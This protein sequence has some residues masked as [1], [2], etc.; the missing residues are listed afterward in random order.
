MTSIPIPHTA[1]AAWEAYKSNPGARN[2]R[3]LNTGLIFDRY[4]GDTRD[5]SDAKR[6]SLVDVCRA[7]ERADPRL[8]RAWNGR[9]AAAVRAMGGEPFSLKTD[10][11]LITGLGRKGPLE[12]GF[13]FHRYGFPYLP[14]SGVKG[15][16]R[17]T[18]LFT[19]AQALGD[20]GLAALVE[21]WQDEDPVR[22]RALRGLPAL[23][24]T[25]EQCKEQEFEQTW[26]RALG[27]RQPEAT[28]LAGDF[29]ATFGTTGAGGGAIFFEALPSPGRPPGLQLDIMNPHVPQYYGDRQNTVAPTNWQ[30]PVPVYFLTVA[31]DTE[32]RFA[33]GW[34]GPRDDAGKRRHAQAKAWLVTGLTE[35][36]A[37][38]KT[39]AGYGFFEPPPAAEAPPGMAVLEATPLAWRTGTVREYQPGPGRGRLTDDETGEE[40]RFTRDAIDEKGWSP[41]RKGKVR[42]AVE[43]TAASRT[44][45][46]VQ[47]A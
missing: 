22:W 9:W 36:G 30:N 42:Y 4:V 37:G 16:A 27:D 7:A 15:I 43:E 31:P 1:A 46:K 13:A 2:Q 32:F 11:R 5:S 25:L 33:V 26:Q 39:S 10:W 44:V 35:L 41:A 24:Q 12:V 3:F 20:E 19:L 40:L 18:G 47:K 23:V 28:A 34:R 8:L 17:A 6:D 21:A 38:A 29:R 45:V 14:A